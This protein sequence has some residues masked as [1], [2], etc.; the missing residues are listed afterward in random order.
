MV[1]V[2]EPHPEEGLILEDFADMTN[3]QKRL[4][5]KAYLYFQ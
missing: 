2:P 4:L 1:K 5:A 3:K